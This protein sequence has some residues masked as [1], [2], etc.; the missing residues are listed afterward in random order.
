MVDKF[1]IR[2]NWIMQGISLAAWHE[3]HKPFY[4][5]SPPPLS[6]L[7]R[8][9]AV[10]WNR[11]AAGERQGAGVTFHHRQ[12]RSAT[13]TNVDLSA[14]AKKPHPTRLVRPRGRARPWFCSRL[15]AEIAF[16]DRK[17]C[18]L[19]EPTQAS[20]DGPY[21]SEKQKEREAASWSWRCRSICHQ[22]RGVNIR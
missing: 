18:Q 10:G 6:F 2:R 5:A 3:F 8:G 17:V 16:L 9:S 7:S 21:Q 1:L 20:R 15:T 13:S 12:R 14:R 22:G 11:Y 4:L 19:N